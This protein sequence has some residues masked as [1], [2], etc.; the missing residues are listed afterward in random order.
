MTKLDKL[1]PEARHFIHQI[2]PYAVAYEKDMATLVGEVNDLRLRG[3]TP[4]GGIAYDGTHY[5]QAVYY[6]A[7]EPITKTFM[8][9]K[10]YARAVHQDTDDGA[11]DEPAIHKGSNRKR[12]S[13]SRPIQSGD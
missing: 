4:I 8:S 7:T 3:F 6:T 9:R 2:N 1:T 5:I 13:I 11:R 10:E 12:R